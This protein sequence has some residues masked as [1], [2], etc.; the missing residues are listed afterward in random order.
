MSAISDVKSYRQ[1]NWRLIVLFIV[2]LFVFMALRFDAEGFVRGRVDALT[3]AAGIKFGFGQMQ[4][5]GLTLAFRDVSIRSPRVPGP[6]S[7]QR[8]EVS[9]SLISLLSLKG[10]MEVE[11]LRHGLQA[12]AV[13][14][15]S[16]GSIE[17]QAIRC[18]GDV[19]ELF[20]MA[21]PYLHLPFQLDL[22]G[23][24][25]LQGDVN[26]SGSNAT[27]ESGAA[28]LVW[29][30]AKGS[31][32]G[33]EVA[34]GT[35]QLKLQGGKGSWEWQLDDAGKGALTGKGAAQMVGPDPARWPLNGSIAIDLAAIDSPTL[36]ALLPKRQGEGM[37]RL[38]LGGTFAV[39]RLDIAGQ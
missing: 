2:A 14:S 29:H 17:V 26:L 28:N 27:P 22:S 31:A 9:P 20:T 10:A 23:K 15:Q 11:A 16:G 35:V 18:R 8:L 4:L 37:I 24:V 1:P 6:L 32:M 38:N 39:P 7:L 12:E 25:E 5:S 13:V 33:V 21:A 36:S 3:A 34:L 30:D 19:A